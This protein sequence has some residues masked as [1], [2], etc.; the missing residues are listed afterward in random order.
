V[1]RANSLTRAAKD[2]IDPFELEP[3]R[4]RDRCGD[5]RSRSIPTASWTMEE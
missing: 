5:P 2:A 3:G 1:A 4:R